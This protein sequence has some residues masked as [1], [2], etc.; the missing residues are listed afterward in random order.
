[1]AAAG[2]R[3]RTRAE[4]AHFKGV[5]TDHPNLEMHVLVHE[6]LLAGKYVD[7]AGAVRVALDHAGMRGLGELARVE[8]CGIWAN[9]AGCPFAVHEQLVNCK[10]AIM[11]SNRVY[12]IFPADSTAKVA[13]ILAKAPRVHNL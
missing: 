8:P 6:D 13:E 10:C 5:E 11:W 1:M 12:C 3:A 4:V 9:N 7:L 2:E